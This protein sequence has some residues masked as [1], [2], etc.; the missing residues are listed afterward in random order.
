V[1]QVG[2]VVTETG[3]EGFASVV[4]WGLR[5]RS[6]VPEDWESAA[7]SLEAIVGHWAII[8][9]EKEKRWNQR[10]REDNSPEKSRRRRNPNTGSGRNRNLSLLS[11]A[12]IAADCEMRRRRTRT[13][14]GAAAG[15]NQSLLRPIVSLLSF[16]SLH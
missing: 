12:A 11:A 7:I 1:V 5:E 16:P 8:R 10:G 2:G 9:K 6:E 14:R 4:P 3:K 13:R 15:R